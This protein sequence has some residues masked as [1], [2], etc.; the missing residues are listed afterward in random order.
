[1]PPR[2]G[3]KKATNEDEDA[4]S[5]TDDVALEH[6]RRDAAVAA[7][8]I[9]MGKINVL[10]IANMLKF[11]TYND[12]LKNN[13]HVN[14][15][16]ASFEKNGIQWG[17]QANALPI[18]IERARISPGQTLEGSWT[19]STTLKEVKFTDQEPLIFAS[20]QHRVAALQKYTKR[21]SDEAEELQARL[22]HL[23]GEDSVTKEEAEEHA[24][25]RKRLGDVK[26]HLTR[27][28]MWGVVLYDKESI[29]DVTR[30]AVLLDVFARRIQTRHWMRRIRSVNNV[31]KRLRI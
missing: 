14:K 30:P 11:G 19:D 5:T 4:T 24:D 17:T 13:S 8:K 23:E 9:G 29:P 12:R 22:K 20:G 28:G 26:G 16:I 3:K 15:M 10:T 25:V 21:Y 7:A 18:V 27:I 31:L 1:M 2:K 6:E